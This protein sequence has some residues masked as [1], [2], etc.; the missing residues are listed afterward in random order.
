MQQNG[1]ALMAIGEEVL[2]G[3]VVNTNAS[4]LAQQVQAL[5]LPLVAHAVVA[6]EAEAIAASLAYLTQQAK[7][8]VVT[9]GLGPTH[10]DITLEAL[11]QALGVAQVLH[12]PSVVAM[13][14]Y[15][16]RLNLTMPAVNRKQALLPQ[17]AEALPNALGTAPGVW[18]ALPTGCILVAL[19]GVPSEMKGLWPQ[20]AQ[21]LTTTLGL[22]PTATQP[23][24]PIQQEHWWLMGLGESHMAELLGPLLHSQ[25]PVV[26]PYVHQG[27]WV[28][29][30]LSHPAGTTAAAAQQANE[31]WAAQLPPAFWPHVVAKT[32]AVAPLPCWGTLVGEV[33]QAKGFRIG[34]AESCTGGLVSHWLTNVAGS[35]AWVAL[36]LCTYANEAKTEALGVPLAL[37]VAHGAVSAPVVQAMALGMVAHHNGLA[38]NPTFEAKPLVGLAI[39]GV[40][41]P[42]GG[43]DDKPVGTAY[44]AL[45]LPA[46]AQGPAACWVRRLQVNPTLGRV[47]LKERF[48]G[49][50]LHGVLAALTQ[51]PSALSALGWQQV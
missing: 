12:E 10:D 51:G 8:I 26:A 37:L 23:T 48:A 18:W 31:A 16:E 13:A 9:G 38:C 46:T 28:R 50:A 20:V 45:Q 41:G 1:V 6:D 32:E 7:V 35:S 49:H 22:L 2:R 42:G 47:A 19:P 5:G 29:L 15:F 3:E 11:A 24:L 4:W 33:L 44:V 25:A 40:A 43:S 14:A 30:R 27:G 17:G 21:R 36:N 34:V 39:S